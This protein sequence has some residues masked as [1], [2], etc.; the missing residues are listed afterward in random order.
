MMMFRACVYTGFATALLVVGAADTL[1]GLP[2]T[3]DESYRVLGADLGTPLFSFAVFADTQ[4]GT[5]KPSGM[6]YYRLSL[7]KMKEMAAYLEREEQDL[8]FVMHLG[9]LT[10]DKGHF[11]EAV[12]KSLLDLKLPV[13]HVLGNHDFNGISS[14]EEV[15]KGFG[16]KTRRYVVPEKVVDTSGYM[17]IVVDATEVSTFGNEKG[18][19][20]HRA[21]MDVSSKLRR[22]KY[23]HWETHNGGV[24]DTQMAWLRAEVKA[25]C[26]ANKTV[27]LFA[28]SPLL[29]GA[30]NNDMHTWDKEKLLELVASHHCVKG[31]VNGHVHVH[32]H[33]TFQAD[34]S[35]FSH[36]WTVSGMVQTPNNSFSVVDVHRDLFLVRGVSWG[37]SFV[38]FFNFT[39][40]LASHRYNFNVSSHYLS[41]THFSTF[42]NH[43]AP[44]SLLGAAPKAPPV[45]AITLMP[46]GKAAPGQVPPQ[47]STA[48]Q[49]NHYTAAASKQPSL[50]ADMLRNPRTAAPS[51]DS[52]VF[53]ESEVSVASRFLHLLALITVAAPVIVF[54]ILRR[55]RQK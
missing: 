27:V 16:L 6:R 10:Q 8:S 25:A 53:A 4:Y 48:A 55:L 45:S 12:L 9:D 30:K 34:A 47:S 43:N 1:F 22:E 31:W 13:Y 51:P 32:R 20:A 41:R 40:P 39:A 36:L 42:D 38:K 37:T 29:T 35:H 23:L 21:A 2:P 44:L 49:D 19:L 14:I 18:T 54:G 26:N 15:M 28:H 3:R 7:D 46:N 11:R 33:V 24:G 17:F 52:V 5:A 50:K